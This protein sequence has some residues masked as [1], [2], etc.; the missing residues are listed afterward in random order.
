VAGIE[1]LSI[2]LGTH[3]PAEQIADDTCCRFLVLDNTL[4]PHL[5][6]SRNWRA[7]PKC[8]SPPACVHHC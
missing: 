4:A 3:P 6:Q 1:I 8:A 7:P 2:S 5:S